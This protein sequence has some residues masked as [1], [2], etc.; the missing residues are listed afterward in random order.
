MIPRQNKSH[1]ILWQRGGECL[2]TTLGISQPR[3]PCQPDVFIKPLCLST[4]ILL[5]FVA[6][7][8]VEIS[9]RV[10]Q[11]DQLLK[12]N[13]P[14][15]EQPCLLINRV[16]ELWRLSLHPFLP[17]QGCCVSGPYNTAVSPTSPLSPSLLSSLLSVTNTTTD[18]L[19][20]STTTTMGEARPE[21]EP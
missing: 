16:K 3:C 6:I 15:Q 17:C 11:L 2:A 14:S 8:H 21:S 4:K 20:W 13:Q 7:S 12:S 18:D 19:G 5:I 9:Q 10:L 1:V